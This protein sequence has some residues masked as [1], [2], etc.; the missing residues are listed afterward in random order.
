ETDIAPAGIPHGP[1]KTFPAGARDVHTARAQLLHCLSIAPTNR[2]SRAVELR[3][4]RRCVSGCVTG[5]V[6]MGIASLTVPYELN[7][8]YFI[9]QQ[10]QR[11]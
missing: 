2:P 9:D 4:G 1:Y 11:S 3:R 6:R 8:R 10:P 7:Y 5:Q